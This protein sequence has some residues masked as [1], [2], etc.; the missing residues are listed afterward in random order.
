MIKKFYYYKILCVH[1]HHRNKMY[2]GIQ[3][4]TRYYYGRKIE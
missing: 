3:A 2:A 4:Y 1:K